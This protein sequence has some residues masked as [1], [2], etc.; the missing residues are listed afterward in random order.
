ML[1][2]E[3]QAL[4][5]LLEIKPLIYDVTEQLPSIYKNDPHTSFMNTVHWEV[6]PWLLVV[7]KSFAFETYM[8]RRRRSVQLFDNIWCYH[9]NLPMHLPNISSNEGPLVAKFRYR[10]LW[11][12]LVPTPAGEET[13]PTPMSA[14]YSRKEQR[15]F[16]KSCRI[17]LKAESRAS[18]KVY[19]WCTPVPEVS[20]TP[21]S[22][23]YVSLFQRFVLEGITPC[24]AVP[25]ICI[26]CPIDGDS[27]DIKKI[28]TQDRALHT[29]LRISIQEYTV[30]PA[31][32]FMARNI[33]KNKQKSE[34]MAIV[35]WQ[36]LYTLLAIDKENIQIDLSVWGLSTTPYSST[37]EIHHATDNNQ[38]TSTQFTFVEQP[39]PIFYILEATTPPKN[40][41]RFL[42]NLERVLVSYTEQCSQLEIKPKELP[43]TFENA[44]SA[45]QSVQNWLLKRT[46]YSPTTIEFEHVL[47][48]LDVSRLHPPAR[49]Y[50]EITGLCETN[51]RNTL[52][53]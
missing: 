24:F 33:T 1:K 35:L 25:G 6:E 37:Y 40:K 52:S 48:S 29:L 9:A 32:Y 31:A 20:S 19:V 21:S 42:V 53:S 45:R 49:P 12:S 16:A 14:F 15:D 13:A 4:A 36:M 7:G 50:T 3:K 44:D 5:K 47:W 27:P 46:K 11:K 26:F 17:L 22:L 38:R 39:T 8:V 41:D 10:P 28:T 18:D 43:S 51:Y 34:S 23:P 2:K 30:T